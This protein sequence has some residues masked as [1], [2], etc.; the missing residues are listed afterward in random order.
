MPMD[1]EYSGYLKTL[2]HAPDVRERDKLEQVVFSTEDLLQWH[3]IDDLIDKDSYPIPSRRVKASDAVMLQGNFE[4]V[5]RIEFLGDDDPSFW[6]G[7]S[8]HG[9]SDH[10]F[11]VDLHRHPIAEIT[12]RCTTP[13]ARPAWVLH[14][15]GGDHFD[16]LQP[17]QQWRTI[18]RRVQHFGFPGT[19]ERI[20]LRLY[21]TTRTTESVE[22]KEI[23]FRAPSPGEQEA[24]AKH[25][26]ALAASGP[27]RHYPL[28]DEFLPLGVVMKAGSAKRIAE[29][30]EVSFRDYWR[31]A[32]EDVARHHHNCIAL[33]EVEQLSRA[34]WREL[35]GLAEP[36]GIRIFAMHDWPMER[37]AE[38]G[39]RLVD[40]YIRPYQHSNAILGWNVCNEPPDHTFRFQ[41]KAQE[42]IAEAD[43]NHPLAVVMRD[44][45][46]FSL[47]GRAFP[48]SGFTHFKTH[49]AWSLGES[50]RVHSQLSR[51]QQFWVVA[52]GFVY[53]TET[54]GW[55]TC[56]EM[57]LMLNLAFANG[58]RGWYTFTYH[59]EPIWVQGNC[60]RSLTGPFLTFS[61]LWAELGHRSERF[62]AMAPLLLAASAVEKELSPINVSWQPHPRSQCP[63][64][65][66]TILQ[67]WLEGPDFQLLYIVS[68][69][70][71][72]VTPVN[73]SVPKDA[74]GGAEIYDVT[75]F[76]RSRQWAP[77]ERERHLEMFPGQGQ[78][79]LIAEPKR[80][81]QLRT[82]IVERIIEN[83]RRQVSLDL[84]LARRYSLKIQDVQRL[85]REI[86]TGSPYGDLL[87]TRDARDRLI[88]LIY[89][90]EDITTPRSKL[91]QASAGI[92]A[93]DGAL[94]R[95]LA[96]G[97]MD[98][99]HEMGLKVL[100]LAR[101]MTALRLELRH[102][103]GRAVS[104][105]C[106]D[107]FRRTTHLLGEIRAL[108]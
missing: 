26:E 65:I 9:W 40:Q 24:C 43:P 15:P 71:G 3:I 16:G 11:P 101:E 68:N 61:D 35:L 22:F 70:I 64:D 19:V 66:A 46:S 57:R 17:T 45:S 34:E 47:F 88:N 21:A 7:M 25:Y 63:P 89:A 1:Y 12:Y 8:S 51:G 81:A 13:K 92:C 50:V 79:L 23:R 56:P 84:G 90:C 104:Q 41:L 39:P 95:L 42:M 55:Y 97:R 32:L 98:Q 4:D 33:E 87:K 77:M 108:V 67:R 48:A 49:S 80:A 107:L 94:C 2:L 54:P 10:R 5:R 58:A 93:C 82:A 74:L 44:P 27:V 100:P 78:L 30:M 6:V 106:A 103:R 60:Q 83:D 36:V 105:R 37:I 75:D 73:I 96:M 20:S 99:S 29:S 102:G 53:A 86:G 14:Y 28:L 52:P 76:V 91:I 38:E 62:L 18:A 72:E 85:L 31:L 59:N 69:D